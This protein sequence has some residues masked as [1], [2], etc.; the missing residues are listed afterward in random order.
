MVTPN[1]D[2][3]T[4]PEYIRLSKIRDEVEEAMR[5]GAKFG[6]STSAEGNAAT[7]YSRQD[8]QQMY[9]DYTLKM[10]RRAQEVTGGEGNQDLD[11]AQSVT[12]QLPRY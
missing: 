5:G 7:F 1:P 4:D 11:F 12:L 6:Q 2:I 9:D 3:L 8:L 10:N